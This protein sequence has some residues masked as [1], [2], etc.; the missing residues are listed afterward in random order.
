ME[1]EKFVKR[2]L[3]LMLACIIAIILMSTMAFADE[4]S[5]NDNDAGS[6]TVY[7]TLSNDSDFVTGFNQNSTV[8]ARVPMTIPYVDLKKYGLEEYYRYEANSFEEGGEYKNQVIVER[9]TL[10]ML[11]LKALG[12]Y[13]LDR[14]FTKDDLGS[15]A[16]TISG[17]AT[18]LYMT[19]FWGHDENLMYFVN[20]AYPLQAEGWGSTSDYIL[21]NDGDVIDVAMFTDW[22]FYTYGCF[23]YFDEGNPS[24][25][26]GESLTLQMLSSGTHAVATGETANKDEPMGGETIRISNDYGRT[27][28]TTS[29]KTEGDP[30]SSDTETAAVTADSETGTVTLPGKEFSVPGVYYISAGPEFEY[31]FAQEGNTSESACVAPPISV[32]EVS[33]GQVTNVNK[34]EGTD[35][36]LTLAW[37]SIK[38]VDGYQIKYK[39]ADAKSWTTATTET[40]SAEIK[41]LESGEEYSFQVRAYV[42]DNYVTAEE[43]SKELWGTYSA[44]ETFTAENQDFD[45]A[46]YKGALKAELENYV[47]SSLYKEAE[48]TELSTLI[49]EGKAAIDSAAD[50]EDVDQALSA[51]K[52]KIDTLKTE[53][54]YLEEKITE[55]KAE[56]K[57][58]YNDNKAKMDAIAGKAIYEKT[59]KS[60]A[61]ASAEETVDN[62]LEEMKTQMTKLVEEFGEMKTSAEEEANQYYQENLNQ[63]IDTEKG[64]SFLEEALTT[65]E[66]AEKEA[67]IKEALKELKANIDGLVSAKI[68]DEKKAALAKKIKTAQALKVSNLKAKVTKA[69][70]KATLSWKKV[71]SATGY[72]VQYKVKGGK[73]KTITITSKN[74]T[75]T[76]VKKLK[77]GKKYSF[78]VR[79][80]TKIEGKKYYG[81]WSSAKA[82]KVK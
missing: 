1:K 69:K 19:K 11:Y 41:D 14:E 57:E 32:V 55:G 22:N 56:A 68:E 60:I 79:T 31:Q 40:N 5:R 28:K 30:G 27:W 64:K 39:K 48:Q 6:I 35:T 38:G 7:F 46:T 78:K 3:T 72:Q 16:L 58:Y 49:A 12:L 42:T 75:K 25:T 59:M 34:Q 45:L 47:D 2:S 81:K 9:P 51:A 26:T 44:T 77:K 62:A 15:D 50:R 67:T 74:T 23:A 24:V 33:P 71:S 43:R 21:L 80:Y 65:I 8:L 29:Y 53:T 37:N 52:E 76:T 20:H 4:N 73:Y 18:H 82:F 36:E 10:L 70:K 13:Y 66:K 54:Q 17:S 63:L 61:K